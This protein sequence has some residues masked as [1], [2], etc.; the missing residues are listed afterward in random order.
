[1]SGRDLLL[2]TRALLRS[3]REV[4]AIAP[5]SS[6]LA[7]RLA[8]V[9][10]RRNGAVVVELGAG[11][12]VVTAKI[13]QRRSPDSTF[14]VFERNEPLAAKLARL[15][16]TAQVASDARD[17]RKQLADNGLT[18]ADA[19]VCGLPWANF[20]T[21]EHDELLGTIID[22]LA[23][24]GVFTTFAYVH[25]L[26]LPQ[27]RLFRDELAARFDEVLPTRA[28]LRNLPPA[29]TYACRSPRR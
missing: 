28:V 23:P 19:I 26:V 14:L 11:T 17:L 5:S 7:D 2:F 25:A 29:I 8:T 24:G 4:G 21:E 3:P 10:P 9:V 18:E 20:S 27:A 22:V 16:P 6:S 13:D 15:A 1:M 12:G